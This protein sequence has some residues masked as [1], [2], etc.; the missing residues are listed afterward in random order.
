MADFQSA[1]L[2]GAPLPADLESAIKEIFYLR[3]SLL[4]ERLR[5]LEQRV[6]KNRRKK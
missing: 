1:A 6:R 2:D 4:Q 5:G 3:N